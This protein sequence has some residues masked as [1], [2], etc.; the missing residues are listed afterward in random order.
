M[1]F[2]QCSG[3]E[4]RRNIRAVLPY[5][6]C[7]K[8]QHLHDVQTE[9]VVHA[10]QSLFF[11]QSCEDSQRRSMKLQWSWVLSLLCK[12]MLFVFHK[13][14]PCC[15][16]SV[17]VT[18]I[19]SL[20]I[21]LKSKIKAP[22]LCDIWLSRNITDLLLVLFARVSFRFGYLYMSHWDVCISMWFSRCL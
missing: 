6:H 19:F 2:F 14:V 18:V 8:F 11:C 9:A 3:K 21:K 15:S 16:G 22:P 12:T 5:L 10:A 7:C 4:E 13:P 20:K 1:I 17:S